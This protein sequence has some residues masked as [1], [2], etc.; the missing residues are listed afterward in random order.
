MERLRAVWLGWAPAKYTDIEGFLHWGANWFG[1]EGMEG[2]WGTFE[3]F[4]NAGGQGHITDYDLDKYNRLPAG[5]GAIMYPGHCEALSSARLEAH[6][7]GLEDL[8]LLEE[9]KKKD[10]ERALQLIDMVFRGYADFEK[11]VDKYRDVRQM[12]LKELELDGSR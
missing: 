11:S 4:Y 1:G 8:Y 10:T 9:L 6:R 7:I 5:D 3:P 12:L 2:I